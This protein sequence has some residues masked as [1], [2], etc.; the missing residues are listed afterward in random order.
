ML[1]ALL[2]SSFILLSWNTQFTVTATSLRPDISPPVIQDTSYPSSVTA[3]STFVIYLTMTDQSGVITGQYSYMN[4]RPSKSSNSVYL[5]CSTTNL[6]LVNGTIYDGTWSMS[7]DIPPEA[8]NYTYDLEIHISDASM[9]QAQLNIA[10]AVVLSGGA[11]PD[12]IPPSIRNFLFADDTLDWGDTLEVTARISDAQTGV[13]SASFQANDPYFTY[14]IICEGEMHQISGNSAD[15]TWYYSCVIPSNID[16]TQYA[17][18]IYAYDG[19]RNTG[20]ATLSFKVTPSTATETSHTYSHPS[21]REVM[22][23]ELD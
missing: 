6:E 8:P 20:Y 16:Y 11:N 19:Q 3:G 4:V 23:R 1:N 5:A 9:N 14:K 22:S 7:C 13:V 17:S 21:R 10:D 18:S 15:G 12:H 2:C